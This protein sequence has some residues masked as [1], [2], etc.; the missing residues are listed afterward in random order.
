MSTVYALID[1]QGHVVAIFKYEQD[2]ID[3]IKGDDQVVA[4]ALVIPPLKL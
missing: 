1:F 4:Y 2:A 3:A